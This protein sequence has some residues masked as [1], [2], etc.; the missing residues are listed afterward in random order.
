MS[1]AIEHTG[2]ITHRMSHMARYGRHGREYV[3]NKAEKVLRVLTQGY[4]FE[5]EHNENMKSTANH[6]N[7]PLAR[8]LARVDTMLNVYANEHRKLTVYNRPQWLAREAAVALGEKKYVKATRMLREL[9]EIAKNGELYQV[10]AFRVHRGHNSGDIVPYNPPVTESRITEGKVIKAHTDDIDFI[11]IRNPSK[12]QYQNLRK[13]VPYQS[14][15]G[16]LRS[17]GKELF[18]WGGEYALHNFVREFLGLDSEFFDYDS[19]LDDMHFDN[20]EWVAYDNRLVMALHEPHNKYGILEGRVIKVDFYSNTVNVVK[21][22][23]KEQYENMKAKASLG[24]LR[25]LLRNDGKELYIWPAGESDH[26]GISSKLGLSHNNYIH[27]H[28]S[29]FGNSDY[30]GAKSPLIHRL[31]DIK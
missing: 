3:V 27:L 2:D 8:Q 11:I 20:P 12:V 14:L 13:R 16:L 5:R 10:E 26:W 6:R 7:I 17:D 21:N 22:P 15:R 30:Y 23:T 19:H 4:G 29:E 25:G 28:G 18:I 9:L 24:T 31:R 1:F